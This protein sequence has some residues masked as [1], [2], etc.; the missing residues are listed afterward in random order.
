M[1]SNRKKIIL[2]RLDG[3]R[4]G[5]LVEEV[6]FGIEFHED[7]AGPTLWRLAWW[8]IH[9]TNNRLGIISYHAVI[10]YEGKRPCRDGT[11]ENDIG[12]RTRIALPVC[13][14]EIRQRG[15]D[16]DG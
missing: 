14:A 10:V 7:I 8:E 9:L 4:I 6:C 13:G 11:T 16:I 2:I 1:N 12:S 15:I 5:L 3:R